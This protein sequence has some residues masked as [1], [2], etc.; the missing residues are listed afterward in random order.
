[1]G[2]G[3]LMSFLKVFPS[4]PLDAWNAPSLPRPGVGHGIQA[5]LPL[6]VRSR[7]DGPQDHL[8]VT[9]LLQLPGA[10]LKFQQVSL[11]RSYHTLLGVGC[12]FWPGSQIGPP[13]CW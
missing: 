2:W 5:F 11:W 13:E 12:V 6:H 7:P 4:P 1:M 8:M 10:R 3:H 9:R